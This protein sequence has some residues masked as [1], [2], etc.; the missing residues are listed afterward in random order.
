MTVESMY[1]AVCTIVTS[2]GGARRKVRELRSFYDG[3]GDGS[4]ALDNVLYERIGMSCEDV[5]EVILSEIV[6]KSH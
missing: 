6:N 5:I 2:N 1:E 3:L 4:S